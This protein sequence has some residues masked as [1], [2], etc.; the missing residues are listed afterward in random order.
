MSHIG[1]IRLIV[2]LSGLCLSYSHAQDS[3]RDT[4]KK[5]TIYLERTNVQSYNKFIN[6]YRTVFTGDVVFRHDSSFMYCDSA[7]FY[8]NENSL[9]AFGNVR[10]EQGDTL[11]VYGDYLYYEGKIEL[12]RMRYN[13]RMVN[14]QQD[15]SVVTLYTDSLDYNRQSNIGYYFEGGRI[16]DAENV[17]VSVYGQYSP[18]TK[19][20][21]FNDSV[22]L[23]N[24]NFVLNSDTLEYSTDTKVAT[25]LGPSVID[26]DS[27][28][29]HSSRGWYN[30]QENTSLLLDR[31]LVISGDKTLTGDSLVYHKDAG[32][33][34]AFGN[35]SICDTVQKMILKG[36]Y[37]YYEEKTDYAFAT[38][39]AFAT[40]YSQG[41]SLF[42][43]G[44][45]LELMTVDSTARILKAY[46]GVR[47]YRSDIQGVADSMR[48]DTRDS[49]LRMYGKPAVLWNETQQLFGDSII[50]YMADSAV[51]H[52]HV[53]TSSFVVQQVDT[54]YYNQLGGN[55]LKAYFSGSNIE[56]IDIDGNAESIFYPMERDSTMLGLNYTQSSYLSIWM[57]ESKLDK[58]KIWPK[59][60]GKL[61]P[62]PDLT[63]EEK[64]L[65]KFAWYDEIRPVDKHDIFRFYKK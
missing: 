28:V 60:T 12:A 62:I 1:T 43:Y 18:G 27:G 20:A 54:G 39:S 55:D 29:I 23:T 42:L 15:S 65:K 3:V 61:I 40:E 5:T 16:V 19:V 2:L 48:F 45:S 11:F 64:T 38:D 63:S 9:E 36:N 31:S 30:T 4:V 50:I 7:Y 22:H 6:E 34:K 32:I 8:E 26:S 57:K 47:F 53:P 52:V 59:P 44:D 58:L 21:V 41:D 14:I 49:V 56:K 25:I 17:L 24:P 13:V 37:G 51:D 46:M 35:M 10:L 33:G